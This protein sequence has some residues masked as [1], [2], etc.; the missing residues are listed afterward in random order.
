M[1]FLDFYQGR[2]DEILKE[3]T[4]DLSAGDK[5]AA[6]K[7]AVDGHS[8]IRPQKKVADLL[9]ND[10]YD[11]DL[12][13]EWE[14]D[15]SIIDKVEFPAG[16]R[17]PVYLEDEDWMIYED[18]ARQVLRFLNDVPSPTETARISYS[19]RHAVTAVDGTIPDSDV[20]GV[21]HLAAA[22]ALQSLANRYQSLQESTIGADSV[23]HRSRASEARTNANAER[24]LYFQHLGMKE[25]DQVKA[26]FATK[27]WDVNFPWGEDRLTHPRRWR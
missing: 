3:Q 21:C 25:N 2:L 9:G 22:F 20:E 4:G 27:D 15:F 24:K 12:P 1:K 10:S 18:T 17:N 5:I 26:G 7:N 19:L 11:L 13:G 6:I 8:K 23:D 14:K 16:E